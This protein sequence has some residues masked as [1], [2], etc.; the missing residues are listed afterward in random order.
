MLK[1][2]A[3]SSQ[4]TRSVTFVLPAEQVTGPV[5]VVGTFN[6]WTPGVHLLR[7]RSNGMF[8]AVVTLPV[9]TEVTF[10]YLADGGVWFD[11]SAADQITAQGSVVKL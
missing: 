2:S 11:E 10:R 9:N 6:D 7:K 3:K 1:L 4:G 8:S 5:S